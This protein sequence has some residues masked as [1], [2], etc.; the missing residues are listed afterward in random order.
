ME[1]VKKEQIKNKLKEMMKGF[2]IDEMK[3]DK[4]DE[5]LIKSRNFDDND[6]EI[7][8][9]ENCWDYLSE[10][11]GWNVKDIRF[12]LTEKLVELFQLKKLIKESGIC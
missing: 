3:K 1:K 2:E 8:V 7:W 6:N 9:Y 10:E 4:N 11:Y 12:E 5:W